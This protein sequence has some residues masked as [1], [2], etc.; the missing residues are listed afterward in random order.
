METLTVRS[1]KLHHRKHVGAYYYQPRIGLS[2][3]CIS[4]NPQKVLGFA[5]FRDEET[6][7]HLLKTIPRP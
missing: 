4:I 6:E 2:V 3:L 5:H 7:D 1:L